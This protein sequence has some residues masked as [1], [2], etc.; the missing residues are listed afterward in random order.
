MENFVKLKITFFADLTIQIQ[1]Q[2]LFVLFLAYLILEY[3]NMNILPNPAVNIKI[4]DGS[5]TIGFKFTLEILT[6]E[7]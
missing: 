4:V 1:Y 6:T 7:S 5:G 3:V 2:L